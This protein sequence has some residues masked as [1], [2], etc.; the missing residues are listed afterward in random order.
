MASDVQSEKAPKPVSFFK[1]FSYAELWD[2]VFMLLGTIG[3]LIHGLAL[4]IYFLLLKN[5]IL[6]FGSQ[7][8][9]SDKTSSKYALYLVYLGL[10]SWA[11]GW[12]ELLFWTYT[13][14]RQTVKLRSKYLETILRQDIE[15]FDTKLQTGEVIESVSSDMLLIQD[16]IGEKMG[17]AIRYLSTF[18]GGNF[19]GFVT[20][21]QMG[22]VTLGVIPLLAG[23]AGVQAYMMTFISSK[24]QEA[25]AQ[26]GINAEQAIAQVRAV[27]AFV[28]ETKEIQAYSSK[29]D[30]A[31][32][33]SY[34]MG[35]VSGLGTGTLFATVYGSFA[36]LIWFGGVLVFDGITDGA[37]VLITIFNVIIGGISLGQAALS[38]SAFSK[39]HG[40]AQKI[41][42]LLENSNGV[43]RL[44]SD[45]DQLLTLQ[46]RIEFQD[47]SF[48]YPSRP[49]V[50]VLQSFSCEIAQGKVVALVGSSGSG[51]ST[52]IA[53][54]ERFYEPSAGH[55]LMDG[56][57]I[58][59]FQV[60]SLRSQLG[61][62]SQEP[63]LFATSIL[64]NIQMG[65]EGAT[66]EQIRAAAKASF[67]DEFIKQLPGGYD[68][69]VGEKG[70]QLSGGQ[71]QRIAIARAVLRN[72]AVLLLDEAT[73]ALDSSSEKVVQEA[74][75]LFMAGRT[76]IV[77]AHRL[78]TIQNVDT[79]MVMEKG[80]L[81]EMGTHKELLMHEEHGTYY[82][83][84]KLQEMTPGALAEPKILQSKSTPTPKKS[85]RRSTPR[86]ISPS[87]SATV[88]ALSLGS[89]KL[90]SL[91]IEHREVDITSDCEDDEKTNGSHFWRLVKHNI[92]EWPQALMG[93][94]GCVLTGIVNPVAILI[95]ASVLTGYYNPDHSRG[96]RAIRT[97]VE[98]FII[99]SLGAIIGYSLQEYFWGYVSER[100]IKRVRELMLSAILSN[101]VGWFDKDGHSSSQ[102]SALLASDAANLRNAFGGRIALLIQNLTVFAVSSLIG[103]LLSWKMALANLAVFPLAVLSA[104][105]EKMMLKGYSGDIERA[106]R[107][108]NSIA[109]EA[110][111]NMRTIAAF[112]AEGR[113]LQLFEKELHGTKKKGLKRGQIAGF[114]LGATK[115]LRFSGNAFTLWFGIYLVKHKGEDPF[116][117]LK[118]FFVIMASGLVI[119]DAIGLIPDLV[120]S[121]LA[122]VSVFR[123]LDR[124]T[125]I[126]PDDKN[127]Q[128]VD[129]VKGDIELQNLGFSY[130][131]R[132]EVPIFRT[133]NLKI[134]A[135]TSLALVGPSGCGKSTIVGLI[136]RFYDPTKGRVT[137]DGLD[138]RSYNLKALRKHIGLVQQEAALF[139]TTIYENIAYGHDECTMA[140]IQEAA[141]A[142]NAHEFIS[143]L[144]EGYN[145]YA[146][147]M[148]VQLSGGQKQRI[149][150]ARAVL[151]NPAILLLDEATSALDAEAE[152]VVQQALDKLMEGRTVVVVAHRLSTIQNVDKIAVL[153]DG[154]II[155]QGSHSFLVTKPDSAY[156]RLIAL[157]NQHAG[158]CEDT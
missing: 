18:L 79:I 89:D 80:Q 74:L 142:A 131:T 99:L 154:T 17:S 12:T 137:V 101:E 87:I 94:F 156:S 129:K 76:A 90:S 63:V 15:V 10:V 100:V 67:A 3:A 143:A 127:A 117:V 7:A 39:A 86:H 144:P 83:M 112:S 110:I 134:P 82:K 119:G 105:G 133:L 26:A 153:Q 59:S 36:L 132:P 25:Y 93:S 115:F 95:V 31:A 141:K 81:I 103:F 124:Q 29:L 47:V 85:S 8:D 104:L 150:I 106:H 146:G 50:P 121:G 122:M 21:W 37:S 27:Y 6:A 69:Q 55:I 128:F 71:K 40:A 32:K 65:K 158:S 125:R 120:K 96:K 157:Q 75:D 53:L 9:I 107:K 118:V 22:L 139:A 136:E 155:E 35:L 30:F 98:Y 44:D 148:G 28:G 52:V 61:L 2:V 38:F 123:I 42:K 140:D 114:T 88:M 72:P 54:L 73:S 77:I 102:L 62:V 109:G 33:L 111:A 91:S 97:D 130:P 20:I 49:D 43:E 135:G 92:S 84:V 34:K 23:A 149:A 45:K 13:G 1:L 57:D 70:I 5:F 58:K 60:Q 24:S 116:D 56:N 151:R 152:K 68:T 19:A 126:H 4:P 138:I 41:F 145:T 46:G 51:K 16:A 147:E 14:E 108:A 48:S 78:S 66:F 113:I 11:A 64:E